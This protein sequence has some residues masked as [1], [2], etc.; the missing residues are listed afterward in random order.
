[1]A[2]KRRTAKKRATRKPPATRQRG[3]PD[4]TINTL[5][6]LVV[7]V[8]VLGGLFFYTQNNKKQA[9]LWQAFIQTIAALPTPAPTA[10]PDQSQAI[11]PAAGID[12]PKD[13]LKTPLKPAA[14]LT[15]LPAAI[16]VARSPSSND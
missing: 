12:A 11:E 10:L 5:V 2:K 8:T 14:A 9:A 4:A 15:P 1:M 13:A 16:A 3:N 7:I 6:I